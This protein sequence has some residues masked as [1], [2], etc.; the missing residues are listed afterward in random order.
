MYAIIKYTSAIKMKRYVQCEDKL[1]QRKIH[2]SNK[3]SSGIRCE[4]S[5]QNRLDFVEREEDA[6]IRG[7]VSLLYA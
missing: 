1:V 5:E 2:N 4:H 7:E 3:N 6:V